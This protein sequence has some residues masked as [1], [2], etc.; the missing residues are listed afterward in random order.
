[1]RDVIV[2]LEA[3]C[4]AGGEQSRDDME[5]SEI[6]AVLLAGA[7]GPVAAEFG[8]FVRPVVHPLLEP[9][10]NLKTAAHP[11]AIIE[12]CSIETADDRLVLS[13]I[14]N[15]LRPLSFKFMTGSSN[16]SSC[17]VSVSA[18]AIICR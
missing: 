16:T 9:V 7:T 2:D 12:A 17:I 6:G 8:A 1:M 10:M 15:D 14:C 4:W 11:E 3:T 5:T 18:A 13:L